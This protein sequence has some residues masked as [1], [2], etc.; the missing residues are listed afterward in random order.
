VDLPQPGRGF[1][2]TF[3]IPYSEVLDRSSPR[4]DS[5]LDEQPRPPTLDVASAA[6]AVWNEQARIGTNATFR[7]PAMGAGLRHHCRRSEPHGRR[8]LA[9]VPGTTRLEGAR[10][11]IEI[12]GER[13][14]DY[15]LLISTL[16]LPELVR[17]AS[18]APEA[19]RTAASRL[20]TNRIFVVNLGIDAPTICDRHWVHF[21]GKD[22]SFFRISYPSN[23]DTGV[24]PHGMSSISAEVSYSDWMPIDREQIVS[25]VVEDLLRTRAMGR[26]Q[27][28]ALTTTCEIKFGY[29]ICD[30]SRAAR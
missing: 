26:G 20:R 14:L 4:N 3:L 9:R 18:D 15:R 19:V 21:V 12:N 10:R 2:D 25:R 6:R 11:R 28:I 27:R 1:A 16:P 24:A 29:C 17:I 13:E 8:N 5:W 30:S 7:Y 22:V 23:F